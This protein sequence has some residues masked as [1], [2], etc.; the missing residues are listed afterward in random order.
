MQ[1]LPPKHT[2]HTPNASA[3]RRGLLVFWGGGEMRGYRL[4]GPGKNDMVEADTGCEEKEYPLAAAAERGRTVQ[5]PAGSW[6]KASFSRGEE[7][8]R[9]ISPL[10]EQSVPPRG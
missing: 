6:E 1:F 8:P 3:L 7:M 5:V 4:T 10:Q 9:R 2:Q